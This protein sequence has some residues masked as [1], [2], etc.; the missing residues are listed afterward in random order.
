MINTNID[1]K[2]SMK[3]S[4]EWTGASLRSLR[5]SLDLSRREF[6]KYLNLSAVTVE[7]WEQN[8]DRVIRSKY[9]SLLASLTGKTLAGT[10]A[11]V[12]LAPTLVLPA[13][14]GAEL[15]RAFDLVSDKGLNETLEKLSSLQKLSPTER[16]TLVAL[17]KKM[18]S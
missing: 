7:K 8:P 9:H 15:A 1:L 2:R 6:A 11:A 13:L 14:A 17:W 16:A 5:E 12:V 4:Q 3:A 10:A 18:N